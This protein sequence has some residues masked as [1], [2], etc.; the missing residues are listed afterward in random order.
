MPKADHTPPGNAVGKNIKH[1]RLIHGETLEE[2]GNAV[3]LGHTA[4][5][6]YESGN[7]LPDLY[8]IEAIASHYGKTVSVEIFL[9]GLS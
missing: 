9:P 1:L 7:R 3:Y 2:L 6:N 5:K 8:I 4:I